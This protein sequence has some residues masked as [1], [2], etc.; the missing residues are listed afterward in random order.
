MCVLPLALLLDPCGQPTD[1]EQAARRRFDFIHAWPL[2]NDSGTGIVRDFQ[3]TGGQRV[4]AAQGDVSV[5][6]R[7]VLG[8]GPLAID[9]AGHA[10]DDNHFRF[11]LKRLRRR[12]ASWS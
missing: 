9:H 11:G 7:C 6:H 3:Q 10:G 1:R 8:I 12:R 4:L 2:E 5:E